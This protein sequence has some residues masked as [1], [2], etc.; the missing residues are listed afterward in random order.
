MDGEGV[1][2]EG[3]KEG[4]EKCDI[5][6]CHRIVTRSLDECGVYF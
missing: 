3:V 1:G 4:V 6:S 2:G 5:F